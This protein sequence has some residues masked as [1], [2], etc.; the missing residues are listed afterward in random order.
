MM[1]ALAFGWCLRGRGR[2]PTNA[3]ISPC[4]EIPTHPCYYLES[5]PEVMAETNVSAVVR[6]TN[7]RLGFPFLNTITVGMARTP[8]RCAIFGAA[9]TSNLATLALPSTRAATCSTIGACILQG[10]HHAAQKST[11]TTPSR[12]SAS[13]LDS[14]SVPT[15]PEDVVLP[16]GCFVSCRVHPIG[17]VATSMA[18]VVITMNSFIFGPDERLKLS[19]AGPA[20][21]NAKAEPNTNR[22]SSAGFSAWLY[23]SGLLREQD[24]L[25]VLETTH[26]ETVENGYPGVRPAHTT[27]R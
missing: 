7:C 5:K 17:N 8:N 11:K 9:S 16:S 2:Q 14:S 4:A 20:M 18:T 27:P 22:A 15:R 1:A 19:H 25:L 12:T 24:L 21:S 23:Y 6:P 26:R 10:P 3:K 13:K